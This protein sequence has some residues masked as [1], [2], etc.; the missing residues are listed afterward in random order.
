MRITSVSLCVL[1]LASCEFAPDRIGIG[2]GQTFMDG[3]HLAQGDSRYDNSNSSLFNDSDDDRTSI[4][5]YGEWDTRNPNEDLIHAIRAAAAG[6]R[7]MALEV[8]SEA[9]RSR[10]A[11]VPVV[12]VVPIVIDHGADQEPTPEETAVDLLREG[13]EV[14]DGMSTTTFERFM[15][16]LGGLIALLLALFGLKVVIKKKS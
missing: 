3:S 8:M 6:A 5:V 11:P 15:W 7:A 1:L 14:I 13:T 12:P 16:I 9:L 10:P 2:V 4:F